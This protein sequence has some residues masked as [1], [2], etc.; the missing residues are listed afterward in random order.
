MPTIRI[1][2][3]VMAN[4]VWLL[5]QQAEAARGALVCEYLGL[6]RSLCR[7]VGPWR[8]AADIGAPPDLSVREIAYLVTWHDLRESTFAIFEEGFM[9]EAVAAAA[10]GF[11][12]YLAATE[13]A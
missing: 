7:D 1:T 11:E 13:P 9:E 6:W 10:A 4:R 5:P 8:Y 2:A 3:R 12:D